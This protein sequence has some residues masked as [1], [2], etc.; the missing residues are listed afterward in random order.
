MVAAAFGLLPEGRVAFES[1][2]LFLVATVALVAVMAL[3]V[4][5]GLVS[6]LRAERSE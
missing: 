6:A 3:V 2:T 1:T 4:G 5:A